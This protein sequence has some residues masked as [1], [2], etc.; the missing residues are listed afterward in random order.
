[1]SL[2]PFALCLLLMV[3]INM[4][5]AS[6]QVPEAPEAPAAPPAAKPPADSDASCDPKVAKCGKRG[7]VLEDA[8]KQII[9]ENEINPSEGAKVQLTIQE[10]VVSPPHSWDMNNDGPGGDQNTK[11]FPV[12]TKFTIR[13]ETPYS[14]ETLAW[15]NNYACFTLIGDGDCSC[16]LLKATPVDLSVKDKP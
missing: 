13:R 5:L 6:A 15:D 7:L 16:N 3:S 14:V 11:V 8:F 9:T 4:Q 2:K 12:R 1:M 10:F